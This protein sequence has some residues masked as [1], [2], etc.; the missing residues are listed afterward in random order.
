MY[1][2]KKN[3]KYKSGT[4]KGK[5]GGLFRLRDKINQ[6]F[7]VYDL[8]HMN[9]QEIIDLLPKEFNQYKPKK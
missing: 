9:A 8:W 6:Y 7:R 3:D 5:P 2:D 4:S 1:F